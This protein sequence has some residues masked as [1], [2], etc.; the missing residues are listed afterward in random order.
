[1]R[2]SGNRALPNRKTLQFIPDPPLIR[3]IRNNRNS[4]RGMRES[5]L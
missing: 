5:T 1:M 4:E 3:S 2:W